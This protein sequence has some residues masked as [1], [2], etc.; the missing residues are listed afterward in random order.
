MKSVEIYTDGCCLG[1][2]G[3]GG[4]G[5][6][7]TYNDHRRELS[8]GYILTTNN[9]M[10]IMGCI[11]ALEALKEPCGVILTTDSEYVVNAITKGWAEKWQQHG[12]RRSGNKPAEN[13]DLWERLLWLTQKHRVQFQWVRG[14]NGHPE[15]ERCDQIAKEA[16]SG[17]GL[18]EDCGYTKRLLDQPGQ[19]VLPGILT[20]K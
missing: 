10:E 15:N 8:E 4:Y 7:L 3:R 5:A 2:P 18:K 11:I 19:A 9:R 13:P 20:A 17:T 14:H 6:I 12:W 1:N 16:A